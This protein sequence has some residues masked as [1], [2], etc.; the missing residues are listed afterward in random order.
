MKTEKVVVEH[1]SR[2]LVDNNIEYKLEDISYKPK[3]TTE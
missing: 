2:I 1:R 3:K